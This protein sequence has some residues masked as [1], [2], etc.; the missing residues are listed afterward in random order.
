MTY[1]LATRGLHPVA[2]KDATTQS[3]VQMW[4]VG[5]GVGRVEGG[6]GWG[7]GAWGQK[8]GTSHSANLEGRKLEAESDQEAYMRQANTM[9]N[10]CSVTLKGCIRHN[11]RRLR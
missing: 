6:V 8:L 4:N 9:P 2:K 1:P 7:G 11:I 10:L 5:G 3:S